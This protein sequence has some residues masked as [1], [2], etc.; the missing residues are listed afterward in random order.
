LIESGIKV[1]HEGRSELA[2]NVTDLADLDPSDVV[3]DG[4]LALLLEELL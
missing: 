1:V 2:L 4:L 3:S